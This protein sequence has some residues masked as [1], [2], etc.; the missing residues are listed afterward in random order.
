MKEKSVR[1]SWGACSFAI[2]LYI[3]E[4]SNV[5]CIQQVSSKLCDWRDLLGADR[6]LGYTEREENTHTTLASLKLRPHPSHLLPGRGGESE[7]S[8]F[9]ISLH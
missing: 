7:C 2:Y 9:D 3:A 8:Q 1:E 6:P 4:S 5:S